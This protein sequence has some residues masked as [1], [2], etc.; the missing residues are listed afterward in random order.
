MQTLNDYFLK[1]VVVVYGVSLVFVGVLYLGNFM[2]WYWAVAGITEVLL[3]YGLSTYWERQWA[4]LSPKSF[5][6]KLFAY[7]L[8]LRFIW[9]FGYYAFTMSV[10]NTPWEQPVGTTMDSWA[11][12]DEAIWLK[13]MILQ[14]DISPYLEYVRQGSVDDAGYPAFLALWNILTGNSI[15]LS[16]FPNAFFDAWTVVLTYR[17]AYRNFGDK[18]ARLSSFFVL[19][20]PMMSFYSAVT[21]KESLMVMLTMWALEKGDLLIRDRKF[22]SWNLIAFILLALLVSFL[23]IAL[24]WVVV[25]TFVCAVILSSERLIQHTRRVAFISV[26]ILAA[27]TVFGGTLLQQREVLFSQIESTGQNYDYRAERLGGNKLVSNLNKVVLA[28]FAL[29]IPLPTMVEIEG[30]NIQQ[31]QNG[32][33]YLKNVLSFFVVFSFFILIKR[34]KWRYSIT[35][36]AFLAGYLM[37][38]AMSSFLHSGRFHHPVVPIEMIFAALGI[39]SIRNRRD[40]KLFDYFLIFEFLVIL[41]WNGFKLKGRGVI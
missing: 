13:E 10:W 7:T 12:F 8:L 16:R 4:L 38:L 22:T 39:S 31:L 21:M 35:L 36:L 2:P 18:V 24:A 11:Y 32:G 9:I 23:R 14:G 41:F 5:E 29:T 30:Q 28:P 34:K 20:I 26:L 1:R 33:Y 27:L 17:I 25:L 6:N 40:A 15:L 19:L 37:V 3:F